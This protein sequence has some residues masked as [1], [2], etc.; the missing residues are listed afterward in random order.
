[1]SKPN[2]RYGWTCVLAVTLALT[3]ILSSFVSADTATPADQIQ[4]PDGFV[5]ELLY[6][7]PLEQQGSWVCMTEDPQGRLICSD[8][9][10]S[11]YRLTL[12]KDGMPSAV[13]SLNIDIG[14]AQ[15]LV[16]AY[17]SL[18][19]IVSGPAAQGSGFYR[20]RDSNGDDQYDEVTLLKKFN[21]T[22]TSTQFRSVRMRMQ[23]ML[24]SSGHGPHGVCLGP[25]GMLYIIG[26]NHTLI[27][28]GVAASSPYR[29]WGE[30][31]LLPRIPD[32]QGIATGIVAPGGWVVRTDRDGKDWTLVCGGLRNAYD[33]AFNADGELLTFDSDM[34]FDVGAAWYR[35]CR[36]LHLIPG[37]EYGWRYGSGKWP[38]HHADSV[39]AVVN[40]GFGSPTGI[41]AANQAE[42]PARYRHAMFMGDWAYGRILA[43]HLTPTGS[44]YQATF[45]TFA[46]GKP[47]A[48]TDLLVHSDGNLYFVIG[49]RNTQSGVYRIRYTAAI[50]S[51]VSTK[52]SKGALAARQLRRQLESSVISREDRQLAIEN[53]NNPDRLIRYSARVS[54]ER[55]PLSSW[56]QAGLDEYRTTASIEAIIAL[57]RSG[58]ATLRPDLVQKLNALSL[59]QLDDSQ[60]LAALR[61]YELVFIRLG[62]ASESQQQSVRDKLVP[63]L[64]LRGPAVNRELCKL[65]VYL[66]EP[67]VINAA[68]DRLA[69]SQSQEDQMYYAFILRNIRTGWDLQSRKD[70]FA[71]LR[72]AHTKYQ[73]G[74]SFQ[75]FVK[76]TLA[77]AVKTLSPAE[78]TA[79]ADVIRGREEV[80][81]I[82]QETERR[83]FVHNWQLDDLRPMI[84]DVD[85]GRSLE[86]GA[87]AYRAAQCNQCHRISGVGG[88]TGPDLTG[89][90]NRFTAMYLLEAIVTPSKV[91]AD[92]YRN[93]QIA[94]SDG[95]VITGRVIASDN[96]TLTVRTHPFATRS[97]TVNLNSITQQKLSSVSEMPDG[98]INT[99]TKD[100]ILDLIAYVRAAG[101]VARPAPENK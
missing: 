88:N 5:V 97:I 3:A 12:S 21:L 11:L 57:A 66:Q 71:W 64:N 48:V 59:Q 36:I 51:D 29:N 92:Q 83:K 35:P 85:H 69:S 32:A 28:N 8:Q 95:N 46:T 40:V 10:G 94:T 90:G 24:I 23:N 13:E 58:D 78:R 86:R 4:V 22:S 18:Y 89:V 16:C 54:M 61:A 93:V 2:D 76:R 52:S 91:I 79:V 68:L 63:L 49:G 65:L 82:A 15:G 44:T 39:G 81:S 100:E 7:V 55:Q 77:D 56:K 37:G 98:L 47:M 33:L 72:L 53:L 73:G 19:V 87:S 38:E 60:L 84:G 26:G 25:D 17:D 42:F 75:G 70:Y 14:H 80:A 50:D 34:E 62:D 96:D 31:L 1:M 27:P 45:E 41:T 30:D 99:L 20:V 9:R 74:Q 43:V 6:S 101:D 67:L